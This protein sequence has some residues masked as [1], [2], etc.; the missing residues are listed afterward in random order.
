MLVDCLLL[1]GWLYGCVSWQCAPWLWTILA[2]QCCDQS[3]YL[4]YLP[5]IF[6]CIFESILVWIARFNAFVFRSKI[7]HILIPC[8]ACL[9]SLVLYHDRYQCAFISEQ[10]QYCLRI[11]HYCGHTVDGSIVLSDSLKWSC[12]F[13]SFK[14]CNFWE[15]CIR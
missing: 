12:A 9:Y 4:L 8:F 1:C 14:P 2:G 6:P 7:T 11:I 15:C 10:I 3:H 13:V 5:S